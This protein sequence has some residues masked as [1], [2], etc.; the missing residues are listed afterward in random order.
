MRSRYHAFTKMGG[1]CLALA[2]TV[3]LTSGC[4]YVAAI[5][6]A[7]TSGGGS[8]GGKSPQVAPVV[9]WGDLP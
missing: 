3:L 2:S 6:I 9:R 7:A 5:V 4:G 1:L 8:S